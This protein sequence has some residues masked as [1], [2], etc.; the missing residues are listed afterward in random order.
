VDGE[1]VIASTHQIAIAFV[2]VVA[3]ALAWTLKDYH[4]E[5]LSTK[6]SMQ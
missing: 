6:P 2:V 4:N 1:A 3:I 5:H